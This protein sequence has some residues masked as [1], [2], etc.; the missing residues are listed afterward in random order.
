MK[1]KEPTPLEIASDVY[2]SIRANYLIYKI[3][4]TSELTLYREGV[5]IRGVTAKNNIDD[6]IFSW[7]YEKTKPLLPTP[8]ITKIVSNGINNEYLISQD[9]FDK[10]D[11]RITLKNGSFSIWKGDSYFT[12]HIKFDYTPYKTFIKIPQIYD[13]NALCP[14]I[15]KFLED[16]F[17]PDTVPLILKMIGYII[18]PS[19]KFQKS[20][21]LHGVADSGKTTFISMLRK[22]IGLNNCAEISLQDVGKQFK[23][24]NMRDKLVNI[25]DDLSFHSK[26]RDLSVFKTL[27]TNPTLSGDIKF[28]QASGNWRNFC[29]QVFTC[30]A[31]PPIPINTG[32]DLWRRIILITCSNK[33]KNRDRNILKKITTQ[34]ELSGLLNKVIKAYQQLLDD[35]GFNDEWE[36]ADYIEGVWNMNSTPL[37]LFIDEMCVMSGEILKKDFMIE[38]N[39]FRCELNTYPLTMN[40]ITRELELIGVHKKHKRSGDYY[41]GISLKKEETEN[42]SSETLDIW[43]NL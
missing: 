41:V 10:E 29:T 32:D 25:Y 24:A 4:E 14:A 28:I 36:Q 22:F 40:K 17:G 33:V 27:V 26:V 15:D 30:N 21:I 2:E 1:D 38:L 35:D 43:E 5:F 20:F 37:K 13:E 23:V 31:L 7:I 9:E 34:S 18:F 39:I 8:Y 16:T 11:D 12:E 6:I 42:I 19:T 3:I